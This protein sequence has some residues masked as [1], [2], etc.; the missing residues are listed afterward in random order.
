[1]VREHIRQAKVPEAKLDVPVTAGMTVPDDVELWRSMAT[2]SWGGAT[3]TR[4]GHKGREHGHTMTGPSF[5]R[6][7]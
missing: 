6:K 7:L 4:T 2:R 5:F 1:M 3:H